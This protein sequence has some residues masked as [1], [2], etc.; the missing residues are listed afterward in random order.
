MGLWTLSIVMENGGGRIV[1]CLLNMGFTGGAVNLGV[2][3]TR[4]KSQSRAYK[5]GVVRD[6]T[7]F[8]YVDF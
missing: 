1:T 7:W 8:M 4:W 6:F 5:Q 2:L 3:L